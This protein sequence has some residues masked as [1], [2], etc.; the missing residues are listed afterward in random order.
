ME[1][2]KMK[3][4][5]ELAGPGGKYEIGQDTWKM[6]MPGAERDVTHKC[7]V[8]GPRTLREF[9]DDAFKSHWDKVF[10]VHADDR[11][12]FGQVWKRVC[13]VATSLVNNFGVRAGDRVAISMRNLPEWCEAFI[14][15][16]SIGAV[17]VPLN[18]WWKGAELEYGLRDSGAKVL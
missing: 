15:A 5:M 1:A 13:S 18:S 11:L 9:F 8:K 17:A 10:L 14:A 6:G 16:T 4:L 3:V 12:T 2:V 7:F